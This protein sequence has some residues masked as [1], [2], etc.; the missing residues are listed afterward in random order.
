MKLK[1]V[2]V[3]QYAAAALAAI[4]CMQPVGV[5]AG[6][7][8]LYEEKDVQTL[9][10]GVTYEK[11]SRLYT[12]G[13]MDVYVLTIDVTN[14]N[15]ELDTM[16]STGELGL[17]QTV[18]QMAGDNNMLAAVNA[19]FFGSGNPFS[20]MGQVVDNGKMQAAQNYYN[21]SENRYAGFFVDSDGVPFI[22]YVKST[23][24]FYAGSNAAFE[25]GAKNKITNFAKPVYFDRSAMT[26]T[27]QLDKRFKALSKIVVDNGVITKLS[28]KGETVTIPENGYIIVMN[29]AT[30]DA[31]MGYY[32]V[33]MKVS[34]NENNSF[35]FRPAK[36][37]SNIITGVS[38]GGELLRNG[39]TVS[40]G[41]IIGKNARNPRTMIG[42]NKNKTKVII[43]CID[44]RA[45]G[46]GATHT[47]AANLMRE[48]GAYDAIHFDGGGSTT[49]AAKRENTTYL[50]VVN[51][52]SEG[53]QRLVA[54]GF[55]V[56]TVG[57]NKTL[58][59][60]NVFP[61]DNEDNYLFQGVKTE[62]EIFGYDAD[63]NYTPV[64][65]N[66]V[67]FSSD[68]EGT[69]E[70]NCF[71]PSVTGTGR[72]TARLNGIEGSTD[73][74][75][76]RGANNITVNANTTVLSVGQSTQL[77][78]SCVNADGYKLGA[79]V[80]NINFTV[81]NEE[82][83]TVE[84]GYFI[85]KSDGLATVTAEVN[86]YTDRVRIA[87]GKVFKPVYGFENSGDTLSP[88]YFPENDG[89]KGG[90]VISSL[91]SSEGALSTRLD[92]LFNDNR[93]T[94]Q[95]VYAALA[96]PITLPEHTA[97]IVLDYL[98]DGTGNMLKAQIRDAQN[99]YSNVSITDS[100]TDTSWHTAQIPVPEGAVQPI[101]IEKFYVAALSTAGTNVRGTVYVDNVGANVP[102]TTPE[103]IPSPFIDYMNRDL[104]LISGSE[105][106][107]VYGRTL[108]YKADNR[109]EVING[110]LAKM[111]QGARAM[112]FA[113]GTNVTN[114]TSVPAVGWYNSYNV[115]GTENFDII[116]LA[117]GSG[118]MRTAKP[119]QW[120]WFR[121]VISSSAKKNIIINMDRYVWGSGENGLKD[122]AEAQLLH[123]ILKKF[124]AESGKNIIVLSSV[125]SSSFVNVKEGVRYIN[126]AGLSSG[127]GQYLRL[128]T[129]GNEL[130][131]QFENL[132]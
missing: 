3:K 122:S 10:S 62:F 108:D 19:D 117:T 114:T 95:C 71:T 2:K 106:I 91:A 51:V 5:L 78:V 33:G 58:A 18:L 131:Y 69:W 50:S 98:G 44:G 72:I 109:Q 65:K 97:D 14:P 128:R 63:H 105:D 79:G 125:G 115:N 8:L 23:M 1:F 60:I 15:V 28:Y 64:D 67:E 9:T 130:Y 87:V 112:V 99:N 40:Q 82:I 104:S 89:I 43:M 49:M 102:A 35:V 38:G 22:D 47:E 73:V 96:K 84:N 123:K 24:G 81:D 46:I 30:R 21:S 126:L 27:S 74:R 34:F 101:T 92:Y 11:S 41:L 29:E 116:N 83:G 52:P 66:A 39:Q 54:N 70:G 7:D 76:L 68:I 113:G 61:K 121:D 93:T 32:L 6:D 36:S 31:K 103:I 111:S 90:A 132:S 55:G 13:W 26:D 85:A 56:R 25:M 4:L 124:A 77:T 120:R 53:S 20:S 119:E 37:V 86:G 100:M 127:C 59:S 75:V 48:Y 80:S 12:A 107:T 118:V 42:V 57:N 129:D 17:K 45:N 16:Q 88:I 94:T 110:M